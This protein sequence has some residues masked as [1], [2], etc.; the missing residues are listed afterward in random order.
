[1]NN[2]GADQ[3]AHPRSLISAFVIHF[4][5]SIISRFATSQI[6]I[7]Q[8]VS[9]AEQAGL[10]TTLSE[11]TKPGFVALWPICV[12]QIHIQWTP[13]IKLCFGSIEMDCVISR[14]CYK[15]QF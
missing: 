11:T 9:V 8:L 3:P 15:G 4:L 6:L 1:M 13:F 14:T 12:P 10:N 2:I 5:E 7:F